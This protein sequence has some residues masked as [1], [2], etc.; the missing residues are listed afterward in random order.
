MCADR[1]CR[2][3]TL[4]E[5]MVG[6]LVALLIGIAAVSTA[7]LYTAPQREGLGTSLAVASATSA[8]T[9]IGEDI[10]QAGLGFIPTSFFMCGALNLSHGTSAWTLN[11]FSPLSITRD[12]DSDQVD[13]IYGTDVAGG[14]DVRLSAPSNL[15]SAQLASTLPVSAGQAVL[16]APMPSDAPGAAAA[17]ICTV[18]TVTSTT[19]STSS[20]PL[21]LAMDNTA[22]H[23]KVAFSQPTQYLTDDR[24]S[25]LGRVEWH[26]FR[27]VDG[28]LLL[29]WPMEGRSAVMM[30]NV[31]A[32]RAQYGA[33]NG[34]GTRPTTI[35]AWDDASTTGWTTVGTGNLPL[36]RALRLSV[37][38]R[39]GEPQRP[40]AAGN[41]TATASAPKL[42][43]VDP[44]LPSDWQCFYYRTATVTVPLRNL[45]W[46]MNPP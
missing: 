20:S 39:S 42:L 3:F 24:V 23:N 15:E 32:F 44:T 26:R 45:A 11:P 25:V 1:R 6:M 10:A 21:T 5:L 34:G 7:R 12:G 38:V 30:R 33:A 2:G 22:I 41:C 43:G 9:A 17:G 16:L 19:V 8:L 4:V 18:R 27:V 36:L 46:G 40:D 29:A 31:V 35:T 28:N 13:V 37:L 14:A